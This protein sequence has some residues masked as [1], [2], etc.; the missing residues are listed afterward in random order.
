MDEQQVTYG[1][2]DEMQL[3]KLSR[4]PASHE[5]QNPVELVWL[6]GVGRYEQDGLDGVELKEAIVW[7]GPNVHHNLYGMEGQSL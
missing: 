3:G 1:D 2:G 4:P 7:Q 6:G 5:M